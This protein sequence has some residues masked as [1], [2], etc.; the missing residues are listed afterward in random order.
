MSYN[1]FSAAEAYWNARHGLAERRQRILT[2]SEAVGHRVDLWPYQWAQLMAVALEYEPDVILELGRGSGNS[3]CAFTEAAHMLK[4][5]TCQVVSICLSTGWNR[6]S[7]AIAPEVPRDWFDLLQIETS[8]ILTYDYRA[9]LEGFDRVLVFWDAHGFDVAECVLGG[10]LPLLADR[11]H[12]LIM[13][14][15]SDNR[16]M[17]E[18]SR[19][20]GGDGLWKGGNKG[21]PRLK[22]GDIDSGVEQAVAISDFCWRNRL[23][24]FSADHSIHERFADD[25]AASDEMQ[26]LLGEELFSLQ[27]HWRW[28]SLNERP[29]PFTFPHFQGPGDSTL[30]RT[31]RPDLSLWGRLK[32][33]ARILLN[34]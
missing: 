11:S 24:L 31:G 9:A 20:Y 10:I 32:V 3:T 1:E 26:R 4:P 21:S 16:Y 33:A 7:A 14:D 2:L 25:P 8:N 27:A 12:L 28:F 34:R 29:G 17:S 18:S 15:L 23:N 5:H 6:T 22:L 19:L 30:D 13:H